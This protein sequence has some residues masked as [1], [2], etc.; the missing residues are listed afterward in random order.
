MGPPQAGKTWGRETFFAVPPALRLSDAHGFGLEPCQSR[1]TA[2]T[3]FVY[4]LF[5]ENQ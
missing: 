2:P 3:R 1:F 4:C 5:N